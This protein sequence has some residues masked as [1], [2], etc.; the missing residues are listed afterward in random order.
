[1]IEY[2]DPSICPPVSITIPRRKIKDIDFQ[3]GCCAQKITIFRSGTDQK[4]IIEIP[5]ADATKT[6]GR[7]EIKVYIAIENILTAELHY[8]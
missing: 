1:M 5:P 4:Y 6:C 2:A 7:F 8:L 3:Q